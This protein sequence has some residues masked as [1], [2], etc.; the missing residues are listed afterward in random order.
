MR[1]KHHHKPSSDLLPQF[2]LSLRSGRLLLKTVEFRNESLP[3]AQCV[4]KFPVS[5]GQLDLHC[6]LPR[7]G[8]WLVGP[9]SLCTLGFFQVFH[10]K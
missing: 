5:A 7:F 8:K 9:A 1:E 6:F 4:A 2:S 3:T 10:I